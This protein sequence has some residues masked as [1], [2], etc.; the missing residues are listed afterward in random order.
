M[1]LDDR[2]RRTSQVQLH[3]QSH[4]HQEQCGRCRIFSRGRCL[5]FT[6]LDTL[7]KRDVLR[8]THWRKASS[9]R[10]LIAAV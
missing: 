8:A 1:V 3:C 2:N 5:C 10:Q 7:N 9:L 4:A 6:Q